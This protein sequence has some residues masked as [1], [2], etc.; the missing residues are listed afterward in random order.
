MYYECI[1]KDD[2]EEGALMEYALRRRVVPVSPGSIYAYLQ[3][4]ALGLRGL[5]IEENGRRIMED[6]GR[7]TGDLDRFGEEFVQLGRHLSN[8][9]TKHDDAGRRLERFQ[10]K[11]ATITEASPALSSE[12]PTLPSKS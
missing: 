9:K 7:L 2:P 6:L 8:A 11:L 4:I 5:Q 10:D 3:V 12:I 1:V